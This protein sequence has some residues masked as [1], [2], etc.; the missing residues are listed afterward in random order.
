[1]EVDGIVEEV[2]GKGYPS[3]SFTD[4]RDLVVRKSMFTCGRTLAILSNKAAAGLSRR[5]IELMKNPKSKME[6]HL[7]AKVP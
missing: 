1:M 6:I 4:P 2:V 7:V 5:L 3:L